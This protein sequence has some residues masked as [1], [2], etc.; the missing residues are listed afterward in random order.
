MNMKKNFIVFILMICFPLFSCSQEPD[1][2]KLAEGTPAYQLAKDLSRILPELDPDINTV[3][4]SSS[5][6]QITTG[7]VIQHLQTLMGKRT[8]QLKAV[9]ANQL[10]AFISQSAQQIA[11]RRLLLNAAEKAKSSYTTEEV[12]N[13][14]NYQYSQAGG[15]EK[16]LQMLEENGV[17][18][19][20]VKESIEKDL[21]IQHYMEGLF[22][23][24]IRVSEEEIQ[25]AYQ[26][27]K[28]ASVRH[29][30]LLT[31]GKTEAEKEEIHQ[32]MEEI[33]SLA[34]SGED[35]AG[36]AKEYSEDPGSKDNGGLY[37]DFGRGQMV[38]PFEDAA[39]SVPVDQIS[40]IV[41]TDYGYHILKVVER[42]KETRPL[43]EVRS[44]IENQLK[45]VKQNDVFKEHMDQLKEKASLEVLEF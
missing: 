6:F 9:D 44:E 15:E 28:S 20:Y 8:D 42:K 40:D 16:F 32:K 18:F 37:E 4:I 38:E 43:E 5:I 26:E 30:L 10:K 29:I 7:E 34:K 11:E 25:K 41:E 17:D 2:V 22:A 3:L 12:D 33:L 39:F 45:Q 36:L 14:L 19:E 27:D 35:F 21:L 23:G 1:E 13:V 31:R 24:N